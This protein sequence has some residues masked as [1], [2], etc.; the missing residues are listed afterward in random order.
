[1]GGAAFALQFQKARGERDLRQLAG[2]TPA[3]NL[4]R[5]IDP[6][7]DVPKAGGRGFQRGEQTGFAGFPVAE[8]A[9]QQL[10]AGHH[11][12]PVRRV[13]D[14]PAFGRQAAQ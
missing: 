12:Y 4:C 10:I 1:M 9:A 6:E 13:H 5:R 11:R 3:G 7:P 14:P 2:G 8:L